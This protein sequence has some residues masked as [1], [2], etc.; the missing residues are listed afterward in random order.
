[1]DLDNISVKARA[2]SE[3]ED[4]KISRFQKYLFYRRTKYEI[5]SSIE[6]Y[7]IDFRDQLGSNVFKGKN[8]KTNQKVVLKL[9]EIREVEHNNLINEGKILIQLMKI[10]RTSKMEGIQMK[11]PYTILITKYIGPSVRFYM[12]ECG[13][14][15]SLETTLK[16]S[17]QV[18]NILQQIHENG[19]ILIYLKPANLLMGLGENKD[20]VYIID[21]NYA[22]FYLKDGEHIKEEKVDYII[23]NRDFISLNVH[24]YIH[25]SRRD[26]IE[27]FGYNLI[28]FM[29]GE[30]PW[31]D[32][33]HTE[34]IK[35]KKI[36][37]SLDELC[38]GLPEE[39]KEFLK[40]ARNMKFE[41][42]PDYEYL[43]GLLQKV[44][45]KNN[46]DINAVKYDW[47]IKGVE[48][49]EKDESKDED[50]IKLN[51]DRSEENYNADD[52]KEIS[53]DSEK[54]DDRKEEN[55]DMEN[56]ND[57]RE[58]ENTKIKSEK[59]VEKKK[60]KKNK[61]YSENKNEEKLE[62]KNKEKI[63]EKNEEKIEKRT[64]EKAEEKNEKIII[65]IMNKIIL[66][67]LVILLI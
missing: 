48:Y 31:S 64:E 63:G 62:E 7:S 1:M 46:I 28:F 15:F 25:P 49:E 56:L 59:I 53:L 47:V 27:S 11:F 17:M 20:Y 40:Y 3:E 4:N 34:E 5:L 44:A 43:K 13:G 18:L 45:D 58:N 41:E 14:K 9:E 16:I 38:E 60:G 26:D 55:E 37:T 6:G 30:L 19:V 52:E 39:F 50:K 66:L 22:K 12:K 23:G 10:E 61:E 2:S 65:G 35:E 33:C 36:N 21:F 57:I 29:K 24:N 51:D 32:L 54:C 42:K 67:M 8:E